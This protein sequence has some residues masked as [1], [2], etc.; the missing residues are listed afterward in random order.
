MGEIDIWRTAHVLIKQHGEDAAFI[1][2]QRADAL[3]EAG[4][5]VGC[6]VFVK[7]GRA[8]EAL[9]RDK[10]LEGEAVN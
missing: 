3:L 5:D 7:I 8:I 6:F 10:P 9:K 1:A 2:A 4:D